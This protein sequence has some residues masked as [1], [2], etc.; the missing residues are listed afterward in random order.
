MATELQTV[1]QTA[2]QTASKA[3]IAI[4]VQGTHFLLTVEEADVLADQIRREDYRVWHEGL[5]FTPERLAAMTPQ[6]RSI[7]NAFE[8][9]LQLGLDKVAAKQKEARDA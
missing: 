8:S 4:D 1:Q 2:Q 3:C 6:Q 9:V 7:A 5:R